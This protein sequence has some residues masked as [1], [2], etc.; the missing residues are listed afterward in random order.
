MAISLFLVFSPSAQLLRHAGY[1]CGHF[2]KWHVGPVKAASPTSP[3]AMGFH[4]WV[5]HDNFFELNPSLSCNGGPP[6][7]FQG[8]LYAARELQRIPGTLR[9]AIDEFE[10]SDLAREAF[11][12][13]VTAHYLHFLRTEQRKF[14]EVVTCWER[15][16]YFERA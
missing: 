13:D 6:E 9:E 5:S 16:R 4:E 12:E 10:R 7:V 11:G 2:G 14:D 3:G 1:Q 8:D 15:A